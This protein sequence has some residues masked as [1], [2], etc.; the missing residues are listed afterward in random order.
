MQKHNLHVAIETTGY[1]S[2]DEFKALIKDVDL[3]LFDMKHHDS[4]KHYEGTGV[5]NEIIIENMTYAAKV[6]K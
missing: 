3:L 5:H 1:S 4:D 2:Q 6:V